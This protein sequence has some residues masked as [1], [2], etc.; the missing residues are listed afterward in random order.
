MIA[1]PWRCARSLRSPPTM[2]AMDWF[3]DNWPIVLVALALFILATGLLRKVAKLAFIGV[4]L[5]AL[6]LVLWP[7]VSPSI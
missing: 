2:S 7:M 4:A 1:G 3:G 5:A 6:G